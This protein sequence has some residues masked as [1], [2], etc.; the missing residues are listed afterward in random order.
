MGCPVSIPLPLTPS[1]C[2]WGA[3]QVYAEL[4]ADGYDVDYF[5]VPVTDEKAPKVVYHT[6]TP[7]VLRAWGVVSHAQIRFSMV[8]VALWMSHAL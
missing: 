5:R 3:Q 7:P 8:I 1:S 4:Q 2:P 6:S